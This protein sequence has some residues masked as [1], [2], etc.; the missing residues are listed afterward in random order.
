MIKFNRSTYLILVV[1]C[2]ML[3]LM[4]SAASGEFD[5]LPEETTTAETETETKKERKRFNRF[6]ILSVLFDRLGFTKMQKIYAAGY[7][8]GKYLSDDLKFTDGIISSLKG[9]ADN[10]N[11]LQIDAAINPGNSGGPIVD[12]ETGSLVGVATMKLSKDYTKAAYGVESENINYG[13]K[14]S[15]VKDFLEANNINISL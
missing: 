12:K 13:I 2:S 15:Q 9:Y 10:S 6:S 5:D 7:P 8:F 11:E 3:I 4:V 1:L 14:S